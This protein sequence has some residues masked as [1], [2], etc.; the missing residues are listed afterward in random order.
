MIQQEQEDER[1]TIAIKRKTRTKLDNLGFDRH[2]SYDFVINKLIEGYQ[3]PQPE[4]DKMY[5][6]YGY[7][8][9]TM[10]R[11]IEKM[12]SQLSEINVISKERMKELVN[13]LSSLPPK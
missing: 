5:E 2:E 10:L 11:H 9:D 12:L 7:F 8:T 13:K 4:I 6:F 1:T 3:L